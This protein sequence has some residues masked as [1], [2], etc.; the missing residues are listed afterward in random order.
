M[1]TLT[2]DFSRLLD[3]LR[4]GIYFVDQDRRI[5]Y[6]N[7]AAEMI[8]G[9]S[10]DEVVGTNCRDNVLIHVDEAGN[11]L[12]K[13]MC[14]L[15]KTM[16]DSRARDA[17]V[18]LHH[19]SGHRVPVSVRISP[20]EDDYGATIGGVELFTD[21]S[22]Q[23]IKDEKIAELKRLALLDSLTRLPNRRH[24]DSEIESQLTMLERSNVRFGLLYMDIDHFKRFNDDHG[25]DVGDLALQTVAR[26]FKASIRPF[27]TIG[28]YG[29]EE[30]VG[31]FPNMDPKLLQSIAERICMLTRRTQVE[32]AA[33]SL[34]T[35]LSIGGCVSR[36]GDTADDIINRADKLLYQSKESGRD[37][38][39]VA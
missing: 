6:W 22:S 35:T 30:F 29:G 39:T 10:A 20:L 14:P 25:H 32:S 27:D 12:C 9:F 24:V 18:Y 21:T 16:S 36:E 31:I 5:T 2:H 7:K 4:D 1:I 15:A 37:R 11:Q 3:N 34:K 8:T 26:T 33:G 17:D 13:T 19:K 28:R 23:R 38:V